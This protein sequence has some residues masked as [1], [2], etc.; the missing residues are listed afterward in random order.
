MIWTWKRFCINVENSNGEHI[1]IHLKVKEKDKTLLGLVL[2]DSKSVI[3]YW[4]E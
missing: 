3:G 1:K 4:S 2:S